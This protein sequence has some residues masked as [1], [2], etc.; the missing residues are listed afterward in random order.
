MV[1]KSESGLA[2]PARTGKRAAKAVAKEQ[3]KPYHHGSLPQALLRAAEVVLKRDGIGGLSLRAIAREAGV[4]HTAPQH[5]FGDTAGVL[6]ELAADGFLRLSASIANSARDVQGT[7]ERRRAIARG[8]IAFAKNN[9]DLMRLMSRGEMFD[10]H[11]PSLV[12]ARRTAG[13]ALAGVFDDAP[14]APSAGRHTFAPM[15]ASRAVAL[16]AAWAYVHGLSLLLIDGRLDVLAAAAEGIG[17]AEELVM[18]AIDH[19]QLNIGQAA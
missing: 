15:D 6:S 16:T 10:A 5:H 1:D 17:N 8:Y 11:R 2:E 14:S 9:P 3:E 19:V 7:S 18:A 13:L 4:S 12:E